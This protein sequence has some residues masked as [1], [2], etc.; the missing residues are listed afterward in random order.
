GRPIKMEGNALSPISQGGVNAR[1]HASVLSL[2][3]TTR[4]KSPRSGTQSIS[5][6]EFDQKFSAQMEAA[7]G[8]PVVMLTNSVVSPTTRRLMTQ[9]MAKYP[10]LRWVSYDSISAS[11][12]LE[13]NEIDFG[14]A[15]LPSYRF[16]QARV[17]MGIDAD[18]LGNWLMPVAYTRD[19]TQ[20]RK[21]NPDK[22]E[23]S[24]HI[25][26]E[27][28][29]SVTGS[30]ADVRATYRASQEALVVANLY[31]AVAKL[32]GQSL[33][34][35]P[36]LELAGNSITQSAAALWKAKGQALVVCGSNDPKVQ[37]MV[38]GINQM[39]G[40]YGS[41]I[42]WSAPMSI[43]QG[44][45]K[46]MEQLMAD[47]KSG[48]VAGL[49]VCGA[50]PVYDHP[51]GNEWM[52][53]I[54][55]A[56]VSVAFSTQPDETTVC[57][58]LIGAC[59]HFLESWGDAEPVAG[60][61]SLQ[62]P[63]ISRLYDTRSLNEWLLQMCGSTESAY[64]ALKSTWNGL[65]SASGA[66]DAG[67]FWRTALHNGV[68][69]AQANPVSS[70]AYKGF[71]ASV[72]SGITAGKADGLDLVLYEKL[73]LGNG[74]HASNPWLQEMPD[75]ISKACW[76]NYLAVNV[77]TARENNWKDGDMVK[78][79]AGSVEVEVPVLVQPGMHPRTVALAVGYGRTEVGVAGKGIGVNAFALVQAGSHRS[80]IVSGVQVS[81]TGQ[82]TELAQTQTHHTIEGR[83]IVKETHLDRYVADHADGNVRPYVTRK[84][85]DGT[86]EKVYPGKSRNAITLWQD[87]DYEGHHWAMAV[88]L[89]A[90]TGCGAC[91]VSC[92][93]ENNVPVV[94]KQEVINR[95]EMHWIRIDRYYAFVEDGER[96]DKENDYERIGTG[97]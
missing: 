86:Y 21:I 83:N 7:A 71:D 81:A 82:T 16:A 88:D 65:A 25:Q 70:V 69:S 61:Y 47:L 13:A 68:Y 5:W 44:R 36:A 3:D 41:T 23:M 78:V 85:A 84:K 38:N 30:N 57:A 12:M 40:S 29:L 26:F 91:V 27:S 19:Y 94:G 34:S 92:Q 28:R 63:A 22:P 95:R 15:A 56:T 46:D 80:S 37:R 50:N 73:S 96:I 39:L 60:Q 6:S 48:A 18:F 35:V 64:D 62:Q 32:A 51:K 97:D 52:E 24:R 43:R 1:V 53:L 33:L 89:N 87:R 74:A 90:C 2:Y 59:S 4:Y 67:A 45:D 77:K 93:V 11:G 17:V 10:N 14:Q 42:D 54:K 79:K 72:A 20:N 66:A 31:N 55:K 8:R 75:P 58:R 49:I 9:A 76:D